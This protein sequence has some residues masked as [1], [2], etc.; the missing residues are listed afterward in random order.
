M[1]ELAAALDDA[2]SGRGRVAMVVGEPGIGKTRTAQELAALAETR[3][4]QVLRG[5]CYEET[6]AP[7][8][9]PWVQAIRAYVQQAGA[10]QL[11]A[12]MGPGAA[13]IAEIV[14]DVR[15][16]LPD[17]LTPQA[18]EPGQARFRLFDSITSFLKNAAQRQSLVLV[19]DDLHWA[20]RSSLLLLEFLAQEIG[21][22][23]LLVLG[24]HRDVE[25]SRGHP[26]SQ[27]LGDLVREPLFRRV[28]LDGLT[29]QEVGELV[30]G[31]AGL[32]L[33]PEAA[34]MVRSRT[35]G[36]PFFVGEVTRQVTLENIT[37][38]EEWANN[39]PEGIRDAIGRRLNRLSEQCNQMLTTASIIGREFD[40]RLLETRT[41]TP[42]LSKL[43]FS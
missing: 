27:T 22:S 38:D 33:T 31:S 32:T 26:L 2:L 14:P 36:N 41:E 9:W 5:R 34:E 17:L 19:L 37:Q 40:F 28:Q 29:R 4:A 10:E 16:K 24:A 21:N 35:N 30:E 25:L 20:D 3:G 7:P 42:I 12:E 6:G 1:A 23:P 43:P 11:A 15:G 13:D 39:I 8:Y 18:L